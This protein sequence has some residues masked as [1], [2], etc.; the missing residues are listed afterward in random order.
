MNLDVN[1]AIDR[2]GVRKGCRTAKATPHKHTSDYAQAT[3][4]HRKA[5][6]MNFPTMIACAHAGREQRTQLRRIEIDR[7]KGPRDMH[8]A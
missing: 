4:D 2:R 1:A 5:L 6:K 8:G 3:T 7:R